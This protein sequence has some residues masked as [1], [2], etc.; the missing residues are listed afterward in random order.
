MTNSKQL[1]TLVLI[2]HDG[3]ARGLIGEIINRFDR[4]GIKLIGFKLVQATREQA[5]MHYVTNDENLTRYGNTTLRDY[6]SKGIDPIA[7]L[8]SDD[9]LVIGKMIKK[10]NIDLL[11][12]GPILAMVYEGPEAIKIVRKIVGSTIPAEALPGTIRGD[13]TWDNADLANDQERSFYNLVHASGNPEEAQYE[14]NLWFK[15]DEILDNY[16]MVHHKA[17]G[18]Y[19]Q[20]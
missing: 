6:A 2:K 12:M 8:G 1:R 9:P 18:L 4:V 17:M 11:T 19:P 7:R 20:K 3:V 13:F 15:P 5:D 16:E 14:I 10:W